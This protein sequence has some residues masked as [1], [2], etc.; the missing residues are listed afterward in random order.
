MPDEFILRNRH[1]LVAYSLFA[2]TGFFVVGA[3]I[4][5]AADG[6]IIGLA[7]GP[8]LAAPIP[9]FLGFA[10]L[11]YRRHPAR[12]S[13]AGIRQRTASVFHYDTLI[14]W[15]QVERMWFGSFGRSPAILITLHDPD[16]VAGPNGGLRRQM[17]LYRKHADADI[18]IALHLVRPSR[19][20]IVGA[21]SLYSGGKI[22]VEP[23]K[24]DQLRY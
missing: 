6:F 1:H 15:S 23:K 20:E 12:I 9:L 14:P 5:I 21:I 22:V 16:A 2:F 19:S 4:S 24:A 7:R 13:A 18:S 8:W 17:R 11:S 10:A 3:V